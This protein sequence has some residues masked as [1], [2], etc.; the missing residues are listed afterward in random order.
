[1]R[2]TANLIICLAL[3]GCGTTSSVKFSSIAESEQATFTILDERAVNEKTSRLEPNSSG[4]D[5]YFGDENINPKPSKILENKFKEELNNELSGK[6]ITLTDFTIHV[7]EPE[8]YIDQSAMDAASSSS[9]EAALVAPLAEIFIS[10]IE[11]MKSE[12]NLLVQVSG[13]VDGASFSGSLQENFKGRV[14]E[15]NVKQ[16]INKVLEDVVSQVRVIVA[17][18]SPNTSVK[19]D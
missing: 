4:K 15:S 6:K 2:H 17:N 18:K 13:K 5:Y 16:T 14:T 11:G 9:P 3:A 12:K 1:M 8:V 19:R 7:Y 10:A